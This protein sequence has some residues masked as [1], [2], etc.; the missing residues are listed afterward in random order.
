MNPTTSVPESDTLHSALFEH[1]V[2]H[3]ASMA[4]LM[5][6]VQPRPDSGERVFDLEGARLF[7]DQL[8]MLAVK[9]RGNLTAG[10]NQLLQNT[11][12]GVRLLFVQAANNPPPTQ[13]QAQAPANSPAAEPLPAP[14]PAPSG[15]EA[16]SAKRFSKKY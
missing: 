6:G 16:G 7:I 14:A 8:E 15:E 10:E 2:Q 5:L 3:L 11:L 4:T 13:A 1:L 12:T 9:T